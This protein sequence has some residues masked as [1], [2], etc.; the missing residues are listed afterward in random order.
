MGKFGAKYSIRKQMMVIFVGLILFLLILLVSVN[1]LFS[2]WYYIQNKK[3]DLMNVYHEV[4]TV[5]KKGMLKDSD[6]IEKINRMA[7][8]NNLSILAIQVVS[9]EIA[10][11]YTNV[12]DSQKL[13]DQ[14]YSYV[15]NR[16]SGYAKVMKQTD[17][18]VISRTRDVRE[19]G[20]YLEMWGEFA[21]SG[22]MLMRSPLESIRANVGISNEF[23]LYTGILMVLVGTLLVW[24]FSRRI[25]EPILELAELSK[26]MAKLDFN[27]KYTRGGDD[28]IAVLGESF[29]TM[30][31]ELETTIS[32]LKTANYELQ[33][34]IRKKEQIETMRT[35]FIGNVSHELKTPIALIQGYAEG[36]KDGIT[37]DPESMDFYCD[38]I[39][40]EAN[41]M[42]RMVK[43]LL[44]LNQL[45][46]GKDET[47]FERIDITSLIS[48]VVQSV[49]ILAK[50][51]EVQIQMNTSEPVYVWADE[52][53]IEQ[54]VRNYISNALNHVDENCIVEIRI[55]EVEEKVRVSVFN[56][57]NP[58]PEEDIG[59][60]WDK[61]YKVDKAHTREYGGNGIGLS[62]VKAI[63]ESFHQKYG[64]KNYE[65]GV[66]F[67]F[68]LD[69]K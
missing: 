56:S 6:E 65:N 36:L 28:E 53:K 41:K 4:Y 50:Q 26:K 63:M 44:T 11:E 17:K 22:Y 68:E 8:K 31:D 48:G 39:I 46:L 14:M 2:E 58:I 40:D 66:K 34:D 43:N 19:G 49:E 7:E 3:M 27:V 35:E 47:Q 57:G 32:E 18:Y 13:M 25:S 23:I 42:N 67:W 60:I 54:V 10:V 30:A 62:I 12:N 24:F 64:V 69:R 55:E 20:E 33:K 38:V 9:G 29:N 5:Q 15:F 21:D 1:G 16:V 61:F 52:F 45:E 37:D 59:H 51:K